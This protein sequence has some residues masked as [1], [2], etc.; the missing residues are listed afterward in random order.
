MITDPSKS[1]GTVRIAWQCVPVGLHKGLHCLITV[2]IKNLNA[3]Y[4]KEDA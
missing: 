3:P 1:G 2:R 4:S